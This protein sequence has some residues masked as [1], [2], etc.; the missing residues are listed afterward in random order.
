MKQ[1]IALLFS[2]SAALGATYTTPEVVTNIA[3]SESSIITASNAPFYQPAS[4][5]L[6]NWSLLSTSAIPP[7]VNLIPGSNVTITTNTP[8]AT[9]TISSTGGS[10]GSGITNNQTNVTLSGIFTGTLNGTFNGNGTG[11][12]NVLVKSTYS[13]SGNTAGKSTW[14]RPVPDGNNPPYYLSV[15]SSN[16]PFQSVSFR[17]TIAGDYDFLQ[18]G[19]FDSGL[20]L[21]M[22]TFTST[23]PLTNVLIGN[24]EFPTNMVPTYGA[25][26]FTYY[27]NT[28]TDY[29]AVITGYEDAEAGAWTLAVSG[30]GSVSVE[31]PTSSSSGG[32]TN[33]QDGVSLSGTFTGDGSGVTNLNAANVVGHL[34]NVS[35]ITASGLLTVETTNGT[36]RME[37]GSVAPNFTLGSS[38]NRI[39]GGTGSA[40][41]MGGGSTSY[42]NVITGTNSR[43]TLIGGGYDNMLDGIANVIVSSA[44]S[45]NRGTHNLIAGGSYALN[46]TNV[47]YGSIVGG[48]QNTLTGTSDGAV[49]LG[50]EGG[51]ITNGAYAAIVGGFS[52]RISADY[53]VVAGRFGH[54]SA[55]GAMLFNADS[56]P[57]TNS[58]AGSLMLAG[59][60]GVTLNVR[61][62]AA[63]LE[64]AGANNFPI[65]LTP[66][67]DTTAKLQF[68]IGSPHSASSGSSPLVDFFANTTSSGSP[69]LRVHRATGS[70][71]VNTSL[72]GNGNS[73]L[74]ALAGSV[75]IGKTTPSSLLDV[76][77][78]VTASNFV[79]TASGTFIGN[80]SGLTNLDASSLASGTVAA[81]RL[82]G[83]MN[84]FAITNGTLDIY[85]STTAVNTIRA[86]TTNSPTPVLVL[87]SNRFGIGTASPGY[88]LDVGGN[89]HASGSILTDSLCV[90]AQYRGVASADFI[91]GST[92]TT[93]VIVQAT[94]LMMSGSIRVTNT[95]IASNLITTGTSGSNYFAG[96][97][98]AT[99]ASLACPTGSVVVASAATNKFTAW[100]YAVSGGGIG[101][102]TNTMLWVTNAGWY[103]MHLGSRLLGGNGAT[104]RNMI[105]TNDVHMGVVWHE[106]L[107]GTPA[108]SD[109]EYKS[110]IVYLPANC[111]VDMRVA[112][113]GSAN[114]TVNQPV[115]K[116]MGA[117]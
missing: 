46:D 84:G 85:P 16:T 102:V 115:L 93:N 68:D 86:F 101:I 49:V 87:T 10:S 2:A 34:T 39:V 62:G 75:A 48:T 95:V 37:A 70:A 112:D 32:I 38:S 83:V 51:L 36:L 117:N 74:N 28:N 79:A 106:V 8:N 55:A 109:T 71:S 30:Y 6:T 5:N 61:S 57:T 59:L 29:T 18:T 22:G 77:G 67:S 45:T 105:F 23:L 21:Y 33:G 64:L 31:L 27:L 52:N 69:A 94:N 13:F 25:A 56:T 114:V 44:H 11:L 4:V 92:I 43:Y 7:L 58:V 90:A 3:R 65:K 50:G 88:T 104:V 42:P 47:D 40:V 1:L 14:H 73:Y 100:S 78:T 110:A 81:A 53:G 97:L 60:G 98:T 63:G 12:S 35:N 76:A 89:I 108:T 82:P 113:S 111:R 103:D 107:H 66:L 99:F 9:W 41:I 80:G 17:V 72:G 96:T 26:G 116:I 54:V 20:F 19:S 15:V 24:D 91:I